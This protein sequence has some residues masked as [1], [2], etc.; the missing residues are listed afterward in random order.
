LLALAAVA[1]ALAAMPSRLSR[2]SAWGEATAA[3]HL[4]RHAPALV[5]VLIGA[6]VFAQ[7]YR[8]HAGFASCGKDL[9]LF[10]QSA[11]LLSRFAAPDNTILGMNAFADHLEFVD[12][13]AAPLQWLWPSA[14]M[15]LLVQALFVGAGA[16]AVADLAKER[17]GSASAAVALALA[18]ALGID[19]Q[20]AVMFDWNPTT[21]AAGLIPWVAWSF[22]RGRL[23]LF[24]AVTAGVALCKENLV[25]SALGLCVALALGRRAPA[26]A[27]ASDQ[28]PAPLGS[29]VALGAA[30]LL[31]CWFV[32][33]MQLI[34]PLFR[35]AG[36]RHLRYE[37]LGDSATAIAR[38]VLAHPIDALRLLVTPSEK[39][40]GLASPLSSVAFV[41][42][43]APRHLV[44]LG[45]GVLERFWSTHANRWG[46]Y[47]Y[48]AVMSAIAVLAAIDGIRWAS[49]RRLLGGRLALRAAPLAL[50]VLL[51][52]V[53]V[54]TLGEP[55]GG[56]LLA[57]RQGY[58]SQ[59]EQ[60]DLEQVLA[61]IPAEASV[62]A[63]NHLL[64]H[65]SA[66]REIFDLGRPITAEYVA[67]QLR[68][69]TWPFAP[70]YPRALA[71]ELLASGYGIAACEGAAIVLAR[72]APSR[73][74]QELRGEGAAAP[75][76]SQVGAGAL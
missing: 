58:T 51:S 65:L 43:L 64:P 39:V 21:C 10:H 8:R 16:F 45:P 46:G 22:W 56:P 35:S 30:L 24:V 29:K 49:E 5:A 57:L 59:E 53:L 3:L 73:P 7:S 69:G 34:L 4:R 74:C 60:R 63:Q 47:H 19:M 44:A 76:S 52:S 12:L 9:G 37:E 2:L 66:R 18:Y 6:L 25:L 50:A 71:R 70:D 31:A 15:M 20:N 27:P 26:S 72:G 28:A 55:G 36:F 17:L 13:L 61:S 62:A 1:L 38:G 33:E 75:A 32:V 54:A 48:G 40:D 11:W 67:L 14:V 41:A 42:L 68:L 23:A